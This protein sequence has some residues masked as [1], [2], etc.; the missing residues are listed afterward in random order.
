MQ[1]PKGNIRILI[2]ILGV[3]LMQ[4]CAVKKPA[5]GEELQKRA[6]ANFI[7]P[8]TWQNCSDTIPIKENWL[9]VF[10]DPLLDTLVGEALV[11]NPDI[12]I[13]SAR[14]EQ[15]NGYVL[16]A[17]AALKPAL[18]ILGR[19]TSKMGGDFNSGLNGAVFSASWEIDL[20]GK[21]RNVRNAEESNLA[22]LEG[23]VSFAKL[24]LAA[25]VAR[26][27]YLASETYLQIQLAKQMLGV[28]SEMRDITQKR[29]D[30]GVG[31]EIDVVQSDANL[32]RLKDGLKQIELAYANQLRA[33]EL[34]LGRYPA[35]DIEVKNNLKVIHTTT[36]AGI[37]MQIL[38]RRPDVLAAQQRF[39]AAFYRVGEAQ[40]ARLPNL[41]LTAGFGLIDSDL[42]VLASDFS[43]PITS[44]GGELIAPIYQ[45]GVLK[46]N[47]YIR[48][49]QQKQ[50]VEEYRRAVL[51]AMADVE[52]T[53]DQVHTVDE[54]E[55][56]LKLAV[57]SNQRAFELEQQRFEVGQVDMRGLI[58][59]QMDL[60]RSEVELLRIRGEKIV[61]RI[62]LY[63][64]LGGS[65]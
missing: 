37:P 16:S 9:S 30:I 35:G 56:F 43:N 65:M 55:Q 18:S 26:F 22:A 33:L 5:T 36:P 11:Y 54:R 38:E 45:G 27:Y 4:S 32:N 1:Y 40:A 25:N 28:S 2:L 29:Y 14:I 3:G 34:L 48:T 53:L 7:L 24:S 15:A 10:N 58:A 44:I 57:Q 12:R 6:F 21:L 31:T 51:N 50:V 46:A 64:A 49:A 13:S 23:E 60:F 19:G 20:W 47:V 63:L 8:S 59:Q 62:N 52:G 42:L 17:Q 41:R 39:N 61:Q